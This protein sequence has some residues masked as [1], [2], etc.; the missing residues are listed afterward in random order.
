MKNT[1]TQHGTTRRESRSTRWGWG[2]KQ[3]SGKISCGEI[4]ATLKSVDLPSVKEL[5]IRRLDKVLDLV[6]NGRSKP[7]SVKLKFM[8]LNK[9]HLSGHTAGRCDPDAKSRD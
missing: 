9:L 1:W 4:V 5:F 6:P 8:E 7:K 3:P 2:E